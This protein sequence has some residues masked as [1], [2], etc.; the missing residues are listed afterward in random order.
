MSARTVR[1]WQMHPESTGKSTGKSTGVYES[2]G[3]PTLG[4]EPQHV[5][6]FIDGMMTPLLSVTVLPV[7][8]GA[9]KVAESIV[10]VGG[11]AAK[12]AESIA[13]PRRSLRRRSHATLGFTPAFPVS[14]P[15]CSVH[16]PHF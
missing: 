3:S 2:R 5:P 7:G 13:A 10:P 6:R 1:R 8:G 16:T 9:A 14:T 11:G 15:H 4:S 12:I